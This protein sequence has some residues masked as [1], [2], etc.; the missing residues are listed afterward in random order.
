MPPI[1]LHEQE[2]LR[3][4]VSDPICSAALKKVFAARESYFTTQSR[5][6]LNAVPE[7]LDQQ[8]HSDAMAK[9]YA[10]Q[11]KAWGQVFAEIEKAAQ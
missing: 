9:H 8:I 2:A 11:A 3:R 10:A 4:I 7:S 6:Q 1:E 5:N